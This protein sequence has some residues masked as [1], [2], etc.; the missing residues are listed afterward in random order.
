VSVAGGHPGHAAAAARAHPGR[1]R[2]IV[3]L[4]SCAVAAVIL[5]FFRD[6]FHDTTTMPERCFP[7]VAARALAQLQIAPGLCHL[8]I[9]YLFMEYNR[10]PVSFRVVEARTRDTAQLWSWPME[11]AKV[12]FRCP[13]SFSLLF[14]FFG[15]MF[16]LVLVGNSAFG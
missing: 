1:P 6:V 15:R 14:F 9:P 5:Y 2:A 7:G 8:E 3:F 10:Y 11:K 4:E 13:F 12:C 16:R